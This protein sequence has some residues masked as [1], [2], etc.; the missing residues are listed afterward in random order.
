MA[1]YVCMHVRRIGINLT[2]FDNKK[3]ICGIRFSVKV[4]NIFSVFFLFF[5]FLLSG[6]YKNFRLQKRKKN[7]NGC[8]NINMIMKLIYIIFFMHMYLR[9]IFY[10]S[11]QIILKQSSYVYMVITPTASWKVMWDLLQTVHFRFIFILVLLTK[12]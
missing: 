11:V 2:I 5:L 1:N 10:T 3:T 6:K 9:Y 7:V 12:I 4:S 8:V